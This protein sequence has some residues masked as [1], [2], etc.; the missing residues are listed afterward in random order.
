MGRAS[1]A[2]RRKGGGEGVRRRTCACAMSTPPP[3]GRAGAH[4]Q[5]GRNEAGSDGGPG[6]GG[7]YRRSLTGTRGQ[8]R[9]PHKPP[10][11]EGPADAVAEAGKGAKTVGPRRMSRRTTFA[12]WSLFRSTRSSCQ[13][14]SHTVIISLA[15]ITEQLY[16]ESCCF[17]CAATVRPART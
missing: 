5:S 2:G 10:R 14:R 17:R 15:E 4:A 7:R 8:R 16:C 6:D 1:A 11:P 12:F 13:K 3:C 9:L